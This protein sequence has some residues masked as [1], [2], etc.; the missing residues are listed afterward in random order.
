M[1]ARVEELLAADPPAP[2]AVNDAFWQTCHGGQRR[3]A[4]YL[5]TRGVDL[6]WTADHSTATPLG[7]AASPGTRRE[8]LVS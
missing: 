2:H 3:V 4:E 6:N 1:L 8:A 7:I 5:L